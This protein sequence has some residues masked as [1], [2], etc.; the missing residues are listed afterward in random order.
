MK[1]SN[2]RQTIRLELDEIIRSDAPKEA[3]DPSLHHLL[4]TDTFT[5]KTKRDDFD[6]VVK[7]IAK[8]GSKGLQNINPN[9]LD[10]SNAADELLFTSDD[11]KDDPLTKHMLDSEYENLFSL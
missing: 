2:E 1:K 3:L 4:R 11:F 9:L 10:F 7:K 8:K 5:K 6:I